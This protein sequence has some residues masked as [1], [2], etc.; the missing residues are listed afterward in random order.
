MNKVK[1][2]AIYLFISLLIGGSQFSCVDHDFP[3]Y[4][5]PEEEISFIQDV[6][7]IIESKCAIASCHNGSL[8]FDRDWTNFSVFQEEAR[9]GN[10]KNYVINRIMP[11]PGS[12]A[13]PLTQEQINTIACWVD[14]GAPN[15]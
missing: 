8:G 5:C 11:P 3:S 6:K 4:T 9:N 14:N 13:G 12:A 1:Q 10:V 7:P 15:N 2:S